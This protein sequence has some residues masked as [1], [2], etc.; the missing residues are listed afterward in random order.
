MP[1]KVSVEVLSSLAN[2]ENIKTIHFHGFS[3][4]KGFPHGLTNSWK[5]QY[6]SI[7]NV[8]PFSS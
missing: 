2:E 8:V 3:K 5:N 1:N 6:I 7:R 4:S